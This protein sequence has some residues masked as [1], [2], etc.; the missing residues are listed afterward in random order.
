MSAEMTDLKAR[1]EA[2][3]VD[4]K[5]L[6]EK[7]DNSTLLK[8]YA[9]FKQA[10]EGDIQGERPGGFDFVAA[11]KHDA[12]IKL[13]GMSRETAMQGYISEVERLRG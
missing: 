2:A 8:L 10:S 4:S 3:A 9:L 11:A 7:P 12:W 5:K 1:F 13:H 6:P